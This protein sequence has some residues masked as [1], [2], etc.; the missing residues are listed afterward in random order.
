MISSLFLVSLLL[1][2]WQAS[3]AHGHCSLNVRVLNPKDLEV[4]AV[5]TVTE[6]DGRV[7]RKENETGGAKFC[8]L[9]L[10]SVTV[11]VGK[12]GKLGKLGKL[13]SALKY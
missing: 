7:H 2:S 11:V 12:G 3:P 6:K 1:G 10:R 4:E 13:G 9:G 8:D 5:I